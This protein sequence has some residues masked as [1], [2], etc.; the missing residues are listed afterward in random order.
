MESINNK[1]IPK[2]IKNLI[3]AFSGLPG[4]GPK[5]AQRLTYFVTQKSSEEIETLSQ[6]LVSV[7][8]HIVLCEMCFY[9][10]EINPDKDSRICLICEGNRNKNQICI[11]ESPLDVIVIE[12]SGIYDGLYHILHGAISPMNGLGPNNLKIDALIKRIDNN[13]EEIIFATNPTLEGEATAMYIQELISELNV[14][15]TITMLARGLPTGADLEY[16]DFSTLSNAFENRSSFNYS[17]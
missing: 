7:K 12:N 6:A 2:P 17:E 5:T 9:I 1:I 13:I 15:P 14:N 11:V 8:D 4:I 3:L 16:S 10:M